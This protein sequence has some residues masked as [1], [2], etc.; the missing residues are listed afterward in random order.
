[1]RIAIDA[2]AIPHK[3]MGAGRYIIDLIRKLAELD[4][5]HQFIVFA[6]QRLKPFFAEL[7]RERVEI[8]WLPNQ[9]PVLRL[10]WEQTIFPR[11]IRQSGADRLHSP[12]YTMP[13]SHPVPNVVTFHDMIFFTHPNM[14]TIPKRI[15][16]PGIVKH[17]ARKADYIIT[18][19]ESTRSDAIRL[20][21]IPPD[22]IETIHL[23]YQDIFRP[24][25]DPDLLTTIRQKYHLPQKFILYAG[26][27]EPRK[28]VP[29]LLTV[30]EQLAQHQPELHL[31]LTGGTGWDNQE[32][33]ALMNSMHF[34]DRI[35]RLGHIDH[36]DLPAIFNLA[37]VFVYPSLYEGFGLP[38]LEGMACGTPVITTNI[39]SMPEVVG[40]TGILVPPN[41]EGALFRAIQQVLGDKHLRQRLQEAGPQRAANF[42]WKH[43]AEKTLE[44]YQR[45]VSI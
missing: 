21:S 10:L 25:D 31:V 41:D 3:P 20:L 28:N 30:F 13:L 9:H 27:L 43:T 1:M 37:D 38:P 40:N 23:G 32:T 11:L 22:K 6:Q 7:P 4:T 39:S 12:H 44:I 26:A 24:L 17:S 42:T 18:D 34:K 14:H 15:F 29:M 33:L 19:S 2:T 8:V 5:Q 36:T 16:F 45:V 35:I